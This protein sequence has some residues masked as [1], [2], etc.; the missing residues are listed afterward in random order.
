MGNNPRIP[1]VLA[2][3]RPKY[4][5]LKGKPL[6]VHVVVN[7]ESW[8]FDAPMP[9]KLLTAPHGL[10]AVPDIP[11]F[12]W[13]EYGLRAGMPRLFKMF[14]DKGIPA[15]AFL[16]AGVVDDYPS[17]AEEIAK[18]GWEVVGH[19]LKQKSMQ[20]E[21]KEEDLINLCL[22][23]LEKF[24]GKRPKGW[25]GPGLKETHDTPDILKK[26]GCTYLC[27]WVVDDMPHWMTTKHGPLVAVPYTIELNDSVLWAVQ[28]HASD[29]MYKRFRDTVDVLGEEAKTN[30]KV[31]TIALHPHLIG[32][33]HRIGYLARMIDELKRRNDTI[34]ITGIDVAEWFAKVEPSSSK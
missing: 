21:A 17:V 16:G 31:L 10:E 32:V 3:K 29:E 14:R 26:A 12:S 24:Y 27:D 9:R 23:K 1:F 20:G 19:G 6:M 34:F 4:P 7:V 2:D 5:P 25:L 30:P 15:S 13:A 18:A 8:P 28:Q 22:E 33:P 11:N